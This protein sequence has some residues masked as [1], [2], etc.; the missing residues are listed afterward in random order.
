MKY[1]ETPSYIE[2]LRPFVF[3]VY[4]VVIHT[5]SESALKEEIDFIALNSDLEF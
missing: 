2:V 3:A 1:L 4:K 5:K